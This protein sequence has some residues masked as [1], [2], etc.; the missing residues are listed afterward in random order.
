MALSEQLKRLIYIDINLAAYVGETV[1]IRYDPRD[2]VEIQVFYQDKYL[3]TT[4]LNYLMSFSLKSPT[5][6]VYL[7]YFVHIHFFLHKLINKE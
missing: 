4:I 2:I 7:F 5:F 3:S 1:I 6:H